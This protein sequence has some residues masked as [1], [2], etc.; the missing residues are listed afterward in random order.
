MVVSVLERV[1]KHR[2]WSITYPRNDTDF[3][4][5]TIKKVRDTGKS[6]E[7]FSTDGLDGQSIPKHQ[8]ALVPKPGMKYR[9]YAWE[10]FCRGLYVAGRVIKPYKTRAEQR[11]KNREFAQAAIPRYKKVAQA[12]SRM[13]PT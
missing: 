11:A 8:F 7:I 13:Q 10:G 4:D 1:N 5:F 3:R 12:L 2:R 9:V 6:W